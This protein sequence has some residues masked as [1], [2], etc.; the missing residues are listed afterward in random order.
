MINLKKFTPLMSIIKLAV[1]SNM[2][3]KLIICPYVLSCK[4][5]RIMVKRNNYLLSGT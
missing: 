1:N 5:C 2:L 4:N 3:E